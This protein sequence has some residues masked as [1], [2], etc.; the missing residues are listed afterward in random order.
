MDDCKLI[1][2]GS[3]VNDKFIKTLRDEYKSVF[4]DGSRKM[5]VSQG[6]LH[7]YLG[8][9]LD[10]S[11]KVKVGITILDYINEI[12]EYLDKE[13][14]ISSGTKSSADPLNLFVVDEECEKLTK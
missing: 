14:A 9:S 10:Y 13:E 7:E 11:V 3:E 5:K 2:Q 4:E 1:H 8:M 12:M 6:K